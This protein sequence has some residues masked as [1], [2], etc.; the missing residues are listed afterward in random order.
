MIWALIK[1]YFTGGTPVCISDAGYSTMY[2]VA[3][4]NSLGELWIDEH[5]ILGKGSKTLLANDHTIISANGYLGDH[6]YTWI[7]Y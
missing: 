2:T 1:A 4:R 5:P 3:Y 6:F 7:S